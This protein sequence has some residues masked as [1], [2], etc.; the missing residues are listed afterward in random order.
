MLRVTELENI[1][2]LTNTCFIPW[3]FITLTY[4]QMGVGSKKGTYNGGNDDCIWKYIKNQFFPHVVIPSIQK[5]K[6]YKDIFWPILQKSEQSSGDYPKRWWVTKLP[7]DPSE[8]QCFLFNLVFPDCGVISFGGV[9][10]ILVSIQANN[11][12]DEHL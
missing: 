7:G 12:K 10:P 11:I 6:K 1:S 9:C 8:S 2:I 5:D 3:L 4:A